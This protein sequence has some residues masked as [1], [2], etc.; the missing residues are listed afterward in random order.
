MLS[1]C[2]KCTGAPVMVAEFLNLYKD[3]DPI[4]LM[5]LLMDLSELG[6]KSGLLTDHDRT[7]ISQ[8]NHVLGAVAHQ[9][10]TDCRQIITLLK[11]SA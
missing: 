9:R 3:G 10:E 1:P 4:R 8:L 5:E 7:S 2:L 6:S 11:A